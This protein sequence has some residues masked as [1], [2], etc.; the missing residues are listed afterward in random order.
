VRRMPVAMPQGRR[1]AARSKRNTG[2]CKR[3]VTR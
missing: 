1:H 2:A 3:M